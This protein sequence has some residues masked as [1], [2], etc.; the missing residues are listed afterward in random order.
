M[1]LRQQVAD[2]LRRWAPEAERVLLGLSGGPD[3]VAA[4]HVLISAGVPVS[5]AHF[6][7]RLRADSGADADFVRRLCETL[8]VPL[9]SGGA[10]VAAVARKRRW[11][12]EDA[13]R[14]L[15][16]AFLAEAARLE[17]A[18]VVV[19]AHT[20][21][22]QAETVL[23]QLLRGAAFLRGMPARRGR[24]VRPLLEIPRAQ[25]RAYLDTCGAAFRQD[26]SN[27][28]RSRT[29]AWLRAEVLPLLEAR[30]PGAAAR[31]AR[32]AALQRDGEAALEELARVRFGDGPL[33]AEALL[34]APAAL[35]RAALARLLTAAGAAVDGARVEEAR[36]ALSRDTPWRLDVGGGRVLRVAYGAVEV[37]V[38]SGRLPE[39]RVRRASELPAGVSARVLEG[40]AEL[41]L[42]S[43][44]PRDRIR[45]PG[46][47]RLLSD[48]FI[49][50]KV[51]REARDG[52]RLLAR[53]GEVLWVEGLAVAEGAGTDPGAEGGRAWEDPEAALMRRALDLAEAAGEA[54]E[55][56]VGAVVAAEGRVL[57][58]GANAAESDGDPTAHA[59]MVAIR[60]AAAAAGDWRLTGATLVVTLEPCPMC[61][62]AAL[63]A[64]VGRVVYGADN[65]REGA[66]GGVVDLR[67]GDWKRRVE[68]RG[69]VLA[70]E[71]GALLSR[72]FAA[73][74]SA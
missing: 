50:A 7:H 63:Q 17:G 38:P 49:D 43:R 62:G 39:R 59:E 71:A 8:Q 15:R 1:E 69:G 73:R 10:D 30:A 21:D 52:V 42:R 54:G 18:D 22:D 9:R 67:A 72:F 19:V 24:V 5:A 46:G 13:A 45:L 47:N 32:T 37:V 6:D 35:Q 41:V 2:S 3:S 51:P 12:V 14:R 57:G 68:V 23:L 31:L 36:R 28:D 25:L 61:L 44:R 33:R 29:R 66:L 58:E 16:Y 4:L 11:N 74:R 70:R 40:G 64:H 26:A 56:P 60:R 20:Q 27:A 48:L 55:L 53:G 65:R 34:R